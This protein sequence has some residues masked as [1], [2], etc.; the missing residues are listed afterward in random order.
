MKTTMLTIILIL[1]MIPMCEALP[2]SYDCREY[3]Y[4][5][6]VKDQL[7]CECCYAFATT[8]MFESAILTN[9][10]ALYDLSEEH[11]KNCVFEN[12]MGIDGGCI[13]GTST[14]VINLYTQTGAVQ[15][16]YSPFVQQTGKC[17]YMLTPEIRV[18]DWQILSFAIVPNKDILKNAIM[19]YGPIFSEVDV[20]TLPANYDGQ[21]VLARSFTTWDGHAILIVGWDDSRSCWIA[22][23]SWGDNWG[24]DGYAYIR[25]GAGNVGVFSSVVTEYEM[26]DHNVRTLY[27][28]EAGWT[29][30]WSSE[31][32]FRQSNP[33]RYGDWDWLRCD[34]DVRNEYV[35]KVEFWTTGPAKDVDLRIYESYGYAWGGGEYGSKLWEINDLSFAHGGYHSIDINRRI[36]SSTGKLIVVAR[37]ESDPSSPNKDNPVAIDVVGPLSANT[38]LTHNNNPAY[39][40]MWAHPGEYVTRSHIK[41]VGDATLRLRVRD[42]TRPAGTPTIHTEGNDVIRIDETIQ[43]YATGG[44]AHGQIE[45]KCTNPAVGTISPDGVFTGKLYGEATVYGLCYGQRGNSIV[46]VVM[47]QPQTEPNP[48]YD[49]YKAQSDMFLKSYEQFT[50]KAAASKAEFRRY[51]DLYNNA[52]DPST[53]AIYEKY[54]MEYG[55]KYMK[56]KASAKQEFGIYK[57]CEQC[58]KDTSPTRPVKSVAKSTM[59]SKSIVIDGT[60]YTCPPPGSVTP[61][62]PNPSPTPPILHQPCTECGHGEVVVCEGG[63]CWCEAA[64]SPSPTPI[65]TAAPQPTPTSTPAPTPPPAPT[66]QPT[67][68]ID[69]CDHLKVTMDTRYGE[70]REATTRSNDAKRRYLRGDD[71]PYN[72]QAELYLLYRELYLVSRAKWNV[73]NAARLAH[74]RCVDA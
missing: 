53:K 18:T 55:W 59:V 71:D 57:A 2:A 69:P 17:D 22:K 27:H 44:C 32:M 20:R 63:D 10:G 11:A 29:T 65:P 37:F 6:S 68:T 38:Y 9:D 70:F 40:N 34:F 73:Y 26:C 19:Q 64:P 8:A 61:P 7:G 43:F 47:A 62:G 52:I 21:S 13:G 35:E 30:S 50:A 23:N 39:S 1:G 58:V 5:S 28:D 46:V 66:P 74:E 51:K 31:K 72:T 12:R 48:D 33:S 14:M 24:D 16:K 45:W 56:H 25:Y 41:H 67:P 36:R 3:G 42:G 49:H 60:I 4:V 15:E 54:Y